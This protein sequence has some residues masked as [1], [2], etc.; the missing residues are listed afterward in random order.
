MKVIEKNIPVS[1]P[2]TRVTELYPVQTMEV[3]DS[4]S[5]TA[6]EFKR[7]CDIIRQF[8]YNH[9]LKFSICRYGAMNGYRVW[10]VQ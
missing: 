6:D 10:R 3:G 4:F 1:K 7:D 9:G 2:S 5:L 8:S